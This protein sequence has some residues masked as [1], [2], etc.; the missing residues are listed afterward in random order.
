YSRIRMKNMG[1]W[2]ALVWYDSSYP[3]GAVRWWP[4]PAANIYELHILVKNQ[5]AQFT[6]LAETLMMPPEYEV[7]FSYNLEVRLRA[8][9]RLPP[10]PVIIAMAKESLNVLRLANVQV[11]TMRLPR[12]VIGAQRAYNVYS[13]GW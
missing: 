6:D 13:D 2:P 7:A 10:D 4:V 5:I 11:P 8:A 12:T 1:T 9:Y 3:M